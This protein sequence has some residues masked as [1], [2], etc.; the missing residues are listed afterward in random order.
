MK[1]RM[2]KM[3]TAVFTIASKNYFAYVRTIMQSLE[4]SNP[5]MDRFAVV[6]DELDDEFVALPRNFQLL[7]LNKLDL[8]HPDQM[9]FRYNIMELNT[10]VKPFAILKLFETYDRVIYFDPDIYVYK[11]LEPIEDALDNGSNFVLTPHFTGLFEE[12][13]LHPDEPDIMR[14]GVYN[15]GFIALNKCHDT[16]EMVTWWGNKL[17]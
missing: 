6:V 2:E 17:E 10:A 8:P 3:K 7:E 1:V 14:A 15:L 12:D 13:G 16:V 11:K 9:K 4:S 5:H